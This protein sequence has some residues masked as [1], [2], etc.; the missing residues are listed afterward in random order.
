MLCN[1]LTTT[2]K[3]ATVVYLVWENGRSVKSK[4]NDYQRT[5]ELFS[6]RAGL[7][8]VSRYLDSTGIP[9]ILAKRFFGSLSIVRVW[10]FRKVL[11]KPFLWK[12]SIEKPEVIKISIDTM[13][14][15]NNYADLCEGVEPTY[16]KVKEFQP[17]FRKIYTM[18]P[19]VGLF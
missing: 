13:V 5:E 2:Q 3:Q 14:L 15:D 9:G 18:S 6:G 11:K 17:K 7:A 4:I 19:L 10:L 1:E 16:K 8:P 12:L